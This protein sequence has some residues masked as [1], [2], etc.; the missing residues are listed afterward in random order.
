MNVGLGLVLMEI[1]LANQRSPTEV[2][3][4]RH[5][6]LY[7]KSTMGSLRKVNGYSIRVTIDFV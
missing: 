2:N 5:I 1:T 3:N 6:A 4:L 7:L